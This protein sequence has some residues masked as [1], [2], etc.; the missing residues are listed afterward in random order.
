MSFV[1]PQL[2]SSPSMP[3]ALKGPFQGMGVLMALIILTMP[4]REVSLWEIGSA[5]ARI[6]DL[7]LVVCFCL[8]LAS[9]CIRGKWL[10]P[11]NTLDLVVVIFFLLYALSILW[12]EKLEWGLY[13]GMKIFRNGMLYILLVGF[14]SI[15]FPIRYRQIVVC[16]LFTGLFQT[17]AFIMS[18][19][20][21]GGI[22]GLTTMLQTEALQSNNNILKVV[23][24]DQGAGVFLRG[25]GFWLPLCI[26][27]GFSIAP[28]FPK[29]GRFCTWVFTVVM[30]LMVIVSG[31]RAAWIGLAVGFIG[32][33]VLMVRKIRMNDLLISGLFMVVVVV[34]GIFFNLH[35]FI[36]ARF[37]TEV[38]W[39]DP[40]IL[41]RLEFFQIALE[42]FS[43]SPILG[44]GVGNIDQEELLIVHNVYLQ[45]LGEL[46]VIGG[47]IFVALIVLWVLAL[48]SVRKIATGCGD[49]FSARVSVSMIGGS[50]FYFTY[51]LVGHDLAGGEPWLI[52]GITSALFTYCERYGQTQSEAFLST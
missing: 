45:V 26:F 28:F 5:H 22:V 31:T 40:S 1:L 15:N 52:M 10:F 20:E 38:L 13:Q 14:L 42:A 27:A 50:L 18:I 35:S 43:E 2:E 19:A 44:K 16:L 47:I 34:G 8:W 11:T 29:W 25:V 23:K 46:G 17:I 48:F 24:L 36:Q 3:P 51:F 6:S 12:G 21:N 32:I 9:G 41:H 7:L 30:V 4:I 39:D 33:G 37:T 49:S